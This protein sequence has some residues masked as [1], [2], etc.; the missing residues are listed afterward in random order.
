MFGIWSDGHLWAQ[1]GGSPNLIDDT[2]PILTDGN[3]Y[4][5]AM[6]RSGT[7]VS[8]FI[9]GNYVFG[10]NSSRD[11]S[12][13][14]PLRIGHN[15]ISDLPFN[16]YIGE[17]RIWNYARSA[18]ELQN[19]ISTNLTAQ[20]NLVGYWDMKDKSNSQF[21]TD[22][23]TT[24]GGQQNNGILGSANSNDLN[25]PV[26]VS[27]CQLPCKVNDNFKMATFQNSSTGATTTGVNIYPNPFTEQ[28]TILFHQMDGNFNIT[29]ANMS[30]NIL[31][32]KNNCS[33]NEMITIGQD[34][35]VGV[36]LVTIRNNNSVKNIKLIKAK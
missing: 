28:A 19:S 18:S 30:G 29:V 25:D 14:G 35:T 23:S 8:F 31:Y 4:H 5:V 36:Y 24:I 17:V 2:G 7:A 32:T 15:H 27:D 16:G 12:S 26:F 13:T 9:N 6:I 34:L 20:A 3:C 21:I 1:L 11:I 10:F 22:L 33:A